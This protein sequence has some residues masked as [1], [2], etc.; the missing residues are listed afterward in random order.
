MCH[1]SPNKISL[2]PLEYKHNRFHN[3]NEG[4][5]CAVRTESLYISGLFVSLKSPASHRR[6]LG[7]I[8]GQYV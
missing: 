1:G 6:G 2:F 5:Y 7:S 3:A 8:P 4:V